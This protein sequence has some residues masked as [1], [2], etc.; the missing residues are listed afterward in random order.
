MIILRNC[1]GK[2]RRVGEGQASTNAPCRWSIGDAL[3]AEKP[4]AEEW[5]GEAV[6]TVEI[7]YYLQ[8]FKF[9]YGFF[10]GGGI[11]DMCGFKKC[12]GGH[13]FASAFSNRTK[14]AR[15]QCGKLPKCKSVMIL[16]SGE[17]NFKRCSDVFSSRVVPLS[18]ICQSASHNS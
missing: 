16:L 4:F 11:I 7:V 15:L 17:N 1:R 2:L 9:R 18:L 8:V 13:F 10:H 5:A 6:F 14:Y 3:S 12:A